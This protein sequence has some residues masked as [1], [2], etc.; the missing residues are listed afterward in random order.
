MSIWQV[1]PQEDAQSSE[2][3]V[4]NA[5]A[6]DQLLSN[7]DLKT[8]S[9]SS[10]DS[11][12]GDAGVFSRSQASA[13]SEGK[14]SHQS[15]KLAF[16][17]SSPSNRECA[18]QDKTPIG[19]REDDGYSS[20]DEHDSPA[21][22][23][24]SESGM[25]AFRPSSGLTVATKAG[26]AP[27]RVSELACPDD[28]AKAY[29]FVNGVRHC[30]QEEQNGPKWSAP[31]LP[32]MPPPS[33]STT[34]EPLA[35]MAAHP[36]PGRATPMSTKVIASNDAGAPAAWAYTPTTTAYVQATHRSPP[37]Y[38]APRTAP[39]SYAT[40][41]SRDSRAMEA[42]SVVPR[43]T[44]YC[45][46]NRM[47]AGASAAMPTAHAPCSMPIPP[48]KAV[49]FFAGNSATAG[50][51]ATAMNSILGYVYVDS[52]GRLCVASRDNSPLPPTPQTAAGVCPQSWLPAEQPTQ[53][54][55]Q[56]RRPC[57]AAAALQGSSSVPG[58]NPMQYTSSSS[59]DGRVSQ[60]TVPSVPV[61]QSSSSAWGST[62]AWV[63]RDNRWISLSM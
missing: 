10:S 19:T 45:A 51:A 24:S 38:E 1:S 34:G 32:D 60:P 12:D 14:Q 40:P 31:P 33:K 16:R 57:V 26:G 21:N 35:W 28:V 37:K 13:F 62:K 53:Y 18:K 4:R 7:L 29:F 22:L 25:A 54:L 11:S 6:W 56:P 3:F 5:I 43:N 30:V 58:M 41:S 46:A 2:P 61:L 63:F 55:Q 50:G 23:E 8:S 48:T 20:E 17:P 44:S 49:P 36:L 39:V 9:D 15:R 27:S 42:P 47:P 52:E 59:A